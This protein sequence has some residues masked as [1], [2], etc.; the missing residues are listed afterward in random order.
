MGQVVRVSR[1]TSRVLLISDRSHS[2]PVHVMRSNLRLIAQGTGIDRQLELL[3][4]NTTAD[5]RMGDQLLS[6]GLGN[7]FPVGYP[8]G[9]VDKISYEPGESFV[10]VTARPNAQLG[11]ARHLLLVFAESRP[12]AKTQ[13]SEEKSDGSS[14]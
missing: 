3:Y 12:A 9:V 2:V 5:I 8:V 14:G 4:V 6:S 13:G 10:E 1:F 11:R 7:R